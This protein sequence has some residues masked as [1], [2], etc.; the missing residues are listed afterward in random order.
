MA[1]TVAMPL[2]AQE[3]PK[4]E[5]KEK[6]EA[7]QRHIRNLKSTF[8]ADRIRAAQ[9]LAKIGEDAKPAARVLCEAAVDTNVKVATEAVEALQ[10]V[11]PELHKNVVSFWLTRMFR[12]E[13]QQSRKSC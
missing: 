4:P 9:E 6:Q 3:K 10:K 12:N 1:L 13:P 2:P 11:W 8:A 5:D 7:I